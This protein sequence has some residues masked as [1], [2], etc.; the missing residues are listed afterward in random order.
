MGISQL[1]E[2]QL[3]QMNERL[4]EILID[5]AVEQHGLDRRQAKQFVDSEVAKHVTTSLLQSVGNP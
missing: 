4:D 5:M 2:R 3:T 1:L